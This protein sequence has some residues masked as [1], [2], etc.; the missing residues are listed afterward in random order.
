MKNL[1]ALSLAT[2]IL[3]ACSTT[4]SNNIAPDQ[5]DAVSSEPQVCFYTKRVGWHFKQK[6]CMSKNTY[7][8]NK[9]SLMPTSNQ[10]QTSRPLSVDQLPHSSK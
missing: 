6:N 2:L 9:V 4:N 7:E 10:S 5:A 3:T 1:F 8:K